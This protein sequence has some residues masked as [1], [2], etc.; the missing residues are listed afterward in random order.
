[1]SCIC[2]RGPKEK[3]KSN[4]AHGDKGARKF[5]PPRGYTGGTAAGGSTTGNGNLTVLTDHDGGVV[6]ASTFGFAVAAAAVV[7]AGE[8][9]GS[10]GGGECGGAGGCGGG[11]CGG[12]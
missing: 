9:G 12:G 5:R 3:K 10:C 2:F 7:D 4:Q 6:L 8:H 1:M 11:G